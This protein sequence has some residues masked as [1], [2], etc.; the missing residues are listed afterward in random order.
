MLYP[1]M[2]ISVGIYGTRVPG[3]G[4]ASSEKNGFSRMIIFFLLTLLFVETAGN[5][6]K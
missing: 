4:V 1:T 2:R 6:K 3:N 5:F